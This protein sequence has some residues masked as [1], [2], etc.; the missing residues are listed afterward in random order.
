MQQFEYTERLK[1]K[2]AILVKDRVRA[3]GAGEAALERAGREAEAEREALM[4]QREHLEG[5]LAE[6]EQEARRQDARA[7]ALEAEAAAAAEK[8]REVAS[9]AKA[10]T[11]AKKQAREKKAREEEWAM[12]ERSREMRRAGDQAEQE[13]KQKTQEKWEAELKVKADAARKNEAK[14]YATT[15]VTGMTDE[16]VKKNKVAYFEVSPLRPFGCYFLNVVLLFK[17]GDSARPFD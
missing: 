3:R 12:H 9:E 16:E 4:A 5:K 13:L 6:A 10:G 8:A 17:R 2:A 15:S 1:T 7:A 11:A 14:A